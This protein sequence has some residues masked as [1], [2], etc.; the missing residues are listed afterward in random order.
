MPI[1]RSKNNCH[2]HHQRAEL[3][4]S[5]L[6]AALRDVLEYTGHASIRDIVVLG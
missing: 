1:H 3:L 6:G 5:A 4:T 2:Y